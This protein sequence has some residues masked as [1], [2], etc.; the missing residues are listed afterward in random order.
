MLLPKRTTQ[1]LRLP[2]PSYNPH[3]KSTLRLNAKA[4][5]VIAII[6][7]ILQII[8]PSRVWVTLWIV[9]G[10]V[11]LLC[12]WWVK[13]LSRSLEFKRELRFGWAQVGDKLEERFTINNPFILPVIWVAVDDHSTLPDHYASLV[14]SVDGRSS[15]QWKLNSQCT[16]RG[17]FTLGSTTLETG[18]PFGIYTLKFEDP[19][20]STV[21]VMPPVISLP[22]FNILASGWAGDGRPSPRALEE[23]TNISH[24]REMVSGD[25]LRLVHWKTSARKNKLHV[26]EFDG[27][28]AGNWWILL[29]LHKDSQVGT[30]WDSTEEHA[31]ILAA[32]LIVQ[33][34]NE[35]HPVGLAVNGHEPTWHIPRRNEYQSHALLKALAI[36]KPS[37]HPL[38]EFIQRNS[39]SLG[40]RSSLLIITASHDPT[41]VE[42]LIPLMRRGILPTIFLFDVNTFGAQADS[43]SLSSTLAELG[44]PCHIIPKDLVGSQ[45]IRRGHEG[46]WKWRV[47]GTGKAVAVQQPIADWRALE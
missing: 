16:H 4:F 6:A 30:G 18:D 7:L 20:S 12:W 45:Q 31:V 3:L 23:T 15:F 2:T 1:R 41:W 24:T 22:R 39:K 43:R 44:V 36:A 26:R 47:T 28:Q 38:R 27:T 9:L 35:E 21:V 8:T 32:S 33:G 46:E 5:P 10:G 17:V 37:E 34:L 29:D 14:I 11:W 13:G 40:R 19:S 25:S 42:D